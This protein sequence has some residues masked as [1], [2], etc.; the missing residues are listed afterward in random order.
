MVPMASVPNTMSPPPPLHPPQLQ[1]LREWSF[2]NSQDYIENPVKKGEKER[3]KQR[4]REKEEK[5]GERDRREREKR[6][7]ERDHL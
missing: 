7:K 5:R 6:E 1:S 3:E 4:D 2:K